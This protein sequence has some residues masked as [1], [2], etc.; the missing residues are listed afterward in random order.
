MTLIGHS[1]GCDIGLP[2]INASIIIIS[3]TKIRQ[4]I[5]LCDLLAE[6]LSERTRTLFIDEVFGRLP[7]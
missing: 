5:L 7:R 3:L 2:F 6:R 4:H 1:K